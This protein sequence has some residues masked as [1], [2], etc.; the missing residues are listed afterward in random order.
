MTLAQKTKNR[1]DLCADPDTYD[2]EQLSQQN[3]PCMACLRGTS[4][5]L[6]SDKTQSKNMAFGIELKI[7]KIV[8]RPI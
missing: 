7:F 3:A 1:Y 4:V 2:T 5:A 6:K 8:V